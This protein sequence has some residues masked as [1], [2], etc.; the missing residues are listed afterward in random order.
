MPLQCGIGAWWA[1][2]ADRVGWLGFDGAVGLASVFLGLSGEGPLVYLWSCFGKTAAGGFL[3]LFW[4]SWF[5]WSLSCACKLGRLGLRSCFCPF[6]GRLSLRLFW[7]AGAD[8]LHPSGSQAQ[9]VLKMKS[10]T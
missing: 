10:E 4:S 2:V 6:R 5:S 9:A 3:D 7:S 1:G 8:G